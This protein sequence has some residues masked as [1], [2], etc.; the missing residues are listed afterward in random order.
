MLI[1]EDSKI[2]ITRGD[3]G[4]VEI[5]IATGEGEYELR[6]GDK[7]ILTVRTSPES[8]NPILL[9]TE[10]VT[11]RITLDHNAT[12]LLDAGLYSADIQLNTADGKVI[13]VWPRLS[14]SARS[15][16]QNWGNFIIMPEV[17]DV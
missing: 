11:T 8:T 13:T 2:F 6:E 14:G 7:L 12:A 16:V 4:V 3:D 5:T 10:S 17:S 9:R 15:K 1:I